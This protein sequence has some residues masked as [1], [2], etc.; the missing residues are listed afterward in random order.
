MVDPSAL[1]AVITYRAFAVARKN[2]DAVVK[3]Q[4]ET[5]AKNTFRDFLKLCVENPKFAY[6]N[7]PL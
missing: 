2:L 3:N 4:R 1:T 7:P 5:P 6:G